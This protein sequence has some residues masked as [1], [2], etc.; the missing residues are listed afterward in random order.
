M[1]YAR[2]V[3]DVGLVYASIVAIIAL[4]FLVDRLVFLRLE[5][6]LTRHRADA[7]ITAARIT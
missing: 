6:R 5:R 7:A 2:T 1:N 3:F 4:V